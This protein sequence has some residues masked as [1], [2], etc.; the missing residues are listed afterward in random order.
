MESTPT[1][2]DKKF[3]FERQFNTKRT[4]VFDLTIQSGDEDTLTGNKEQVEQVAVL[5]VSGK[6]LKSS[7]SI[8]RVQEGQAQEKILTE[9]EDPPV[10]YSTY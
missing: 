7:T 6:K 3:L 2:S 5:R 10:I 9:E 8:V 4:L 1:S